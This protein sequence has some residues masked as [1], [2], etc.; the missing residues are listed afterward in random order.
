VNR[1]VLRARVLAGGA[2]AAALALAGCGDNNNNAGGG[3]ATTAPAL[4]GAV[5]IDGSSTVEP[6]TSAA[7]DLFKEVQ[8]GV[9]VTVGTS[10]TGGGFE[11][12]CKG[13]TDISDASR[14]INDK[15]KAACTTGN[16]QWTELG[17]AND[18]LTVAIH[19]DNTWATCMTVDQLKKIW[20]PAAQGK[21]TNWNQIDPAFPNEPLKLF[22]PGTDSGTFDYF[23]AVIVGTEGDSRQDATFSEND[24]VLV[25]GVSTT[26]GGLGYFGF[27]YFEENQGNL[28]A[29]QINNGSGCV[30]PTLET[31]QNGTYKPLSRPLFIYV[32]NAS[33]TKPQVKAFIDFY[34]TKND[35]IIKEAG[36]VPLTAA[37]ETQLTTNHSSLE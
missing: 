35:E 13:E 17:I 4:S 25:Q 32:K 37:Q 15:E 18:A 30:A 21:I 36:F 5:A 27:S 14:K 16:I 1:N 34:V 28:K 24:N 31:A 12:F 22:S 19:K 29:V 2:L 8:P 7:A 10:G 26:K 11:K 3:G 20:E 9:N 33:W 23:T 6:L